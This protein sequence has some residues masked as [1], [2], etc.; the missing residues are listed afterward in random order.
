MARKQETRSARRRGNQNPGTTW[1]RRWRWPLIGILALLLIVAPASAIGVSVHMENNDAFC[2]SCH[3]QP[4]TDYVAR[5]EAVRQGQAEPA[6]L[7]AVHA[8]AE[9][10]V[11]CIA[12]HSGAGMLGR[13]DA[14]TLGA[15]DLVAYTRGNFPQPA[16]LTHP[17][18]DANCIKCHQD[19]AKSR[20]FDNHYHL[21]LARW[22]KF[23][24]DNA[25]TCVDCHSGHV[26][27]GEAQLA[28][29]NRPRVEAQCNA[30]HRV[31]GD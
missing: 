9:Q 3:T 30:C 5:A 22:Q 27:D 7:A 26:Q 8:G 19:Y 17:I 14:L 13:V 24:G 6:D 10:P 12:C 23:A 2:A 16:P 29:L 21:F 4:E 28:F 20:S 25:A 31:M 11:G 18:G 15:R 1:W